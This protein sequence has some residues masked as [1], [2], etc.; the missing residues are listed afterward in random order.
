MNTCYS[1]CISLSLTL[2]LSFSPYNNSY[3]CNDVAP[4]SSGDFTSELLFHGYLFEIYLVWSKEIHHSHKI[5]VY[6]ELKILPTK[7]LCH[8]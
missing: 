5:H 6:R 4:F 7:V 8:P 3:V 1:S 2:A